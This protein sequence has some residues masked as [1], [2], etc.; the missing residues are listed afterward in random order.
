MQ[1]ATA[2]SDWVQT[3]GVECL[4]YVQTLQSMGY[5]T[6]QDIVLASPRPDQLK[7]A[8][9]AVPSARRRIWH[10]TQRLRLQATAGQKVGASP[11]ACV[12]A[13]SSGALLPGCAARTAARNCVARTL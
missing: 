13:P 6:V 10:A 1:P 9:V 7:Q 11:P 8:G 4:P 12:H 3:L 5:Q 2:I